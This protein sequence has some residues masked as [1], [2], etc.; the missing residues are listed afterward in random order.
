M[1][2]VMVA[3]LGYGLALFAFG[4]GLNGLGDYRNLK[5]VAGKGA[6]ALVALVI[7]AIS[8]FFAFGFAAITYV[9]LK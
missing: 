7:S 4:V 5:G 1:G 9:V 8:F 6:E 3:V 2:G